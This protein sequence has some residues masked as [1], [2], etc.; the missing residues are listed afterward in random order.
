MSGDRQHETRLLSPLAYKDE[1]NTLRKDLSVAV[2]GLTLEM[3]DVLVRGVFTG[4]KRHRGVTL[5]CVD[6]R[7]VYNPMPPK[8]G[9]IYPAQELKAVVNF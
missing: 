9:D 5:G 1:L 7:W 3:E 6:I 2:F 8:P 4:F